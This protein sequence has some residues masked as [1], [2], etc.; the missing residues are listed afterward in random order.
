MTPALAHSYC[1]TGLPGERA[2]R[3]VHVREVAGEV[4]AGDV[5][6]VDRLDRAAV[7]FLDAAA[8]LHPF[9]AR[10]LQARSRRRS[11]RRCRCRGR[12]CRRPAGSARWRPR[13]STISRTGTRRSGAAS[14]FAVDLARGG[15]RP[16]G[17]LGRGEIG[18]GDM[19]VH[20]CA[21]SL[22][23]AG[24]FVE[25]VFV[26]R[27][28]VEIAEEGEAS[29]RARARC[30]PRHAAPSCSRAWR[31]RRFSVL[32]GQTMRAAPPI[33]MSQPRMVIN[34]G[35]LATQTLWVS[36]M[37][38]PAV[39]VRRPER[40]ISAAAAQEFFGEAAKAVPVDEHA[41]CPT[42]SI[43]G[44]ISFARKIEFAIGKRSC[45]FAG[46]TRIRFKGSPRCP[47]WRRAVSQLP[48]G[49]PLGTPLM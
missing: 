34:T 19:L 42:T 49:A 3:L 25:R 17:D 12:W 23:R 43:T 20:F 40:K 26:E 44:P 27:K 22:S 15:E 47:S 18:A 39:M 33:V 5:A 2:Q 41:R 1:V 48:A 21:C 14:G 30:R 37:A 6:V 36:T 13:C 10:A 45:P 32:C 46:M 4:L 29:R 24:E 7:V 16:G 35:Q 28:L 11:R 9:G 38:R 8:L 31:G